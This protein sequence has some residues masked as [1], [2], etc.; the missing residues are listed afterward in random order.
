MFL[1]ADVFEKC[2]MCLEY[3]GLDPCHYFSS[4]GLSWSAMLKMTGVELELVLEK[5]FQGSFSY[6]AKIY[7][8]AN[9]RYIQSY[10]NNKPSKF[11]MYLDENNLYACTM[12]QYLACG[13]FEWLNQKEIDRLNVNSIGKSSPI[14]YILEVDLDYPAE[15]YELH[16]DYPLAPEN[17][18]A[19][20]TMHSNY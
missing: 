13:R 15:L 18:D 20:N 19:S 5:F 1:L 7:S 11:I 14:D 16:N 8:K 10:D 3:S 9:N 6:F 4:P 12:S 17:H 2:I